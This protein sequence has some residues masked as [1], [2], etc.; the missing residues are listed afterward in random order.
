MLG[1]RALDAALAARLPGPGLRRLAVRFEYDCSA[2]AVPYASECEVAAVKAMPRMRAAGV[3]EIVS[4]SNL[5]R[6]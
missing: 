1:L 5:E 2:A 6:P 4:W 3:L